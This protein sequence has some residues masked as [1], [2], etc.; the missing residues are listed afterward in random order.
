MELSNAL[1]QIEPTLET[2]RAVIASR[3]QNPLT[4]ARALSVLLEMNDTAVN[5][6][7]T[8]RAH[9]QAAEA[10]RLEESPRRIAALEREAK[11]RE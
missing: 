11:K 5:A 3:T 10:I 9:M 7:E 1:N 6:M 8:A 4:L 2:V